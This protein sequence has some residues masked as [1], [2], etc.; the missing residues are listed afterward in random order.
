MAMVIGYAIDLPRR[1]TQAGVETIAQVNSRN[2]FLKKHG[3]LNGNAIDLWDRS[4]A[5]IPNNITKVSTFPLQVERLR[6]PCGCSG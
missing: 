3:I 4:D 5:K 2:V 1:G 6:A